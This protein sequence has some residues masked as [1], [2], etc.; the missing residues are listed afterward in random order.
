MDSGAL[1]KELLADSPVEI[2]IS[3]KRA[4][5]NE[6]GMLVG[7]PMETKSSKKQALAKELMTLAD[8]LLKTESSNNSK[9]CTM[10]TPESLMATYERLKAEFEEIVAVKEQSSPGKTMASIEEMAPRGMGSPGELPKV[11][12]MA[13]HNCGF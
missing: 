10:P 2:E 11:K 5:A 9:G 6:L 4:S 12:N 13:C 8:E 1:G 3:K 7:K